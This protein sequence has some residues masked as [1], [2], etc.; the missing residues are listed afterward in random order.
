[1]NHMPEY[2][3]FTEEDLLLAALA[4]E[5]YGDAPEGFGPTDLRQRLQD[6]RNWLDGWLARRRTDIC[7]EL[8][9][10]GLRSS[11][12]MEA[13]VDVATLTDVVLGLGLGQASAVIVAALLLK[14]GIRNLC[15]SL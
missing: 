6:A 10:R 4:A 12:T 9:R 2:D 11:G 7:A 3:Q 14:W 15:T 1:V 5:L 13:L 8:D